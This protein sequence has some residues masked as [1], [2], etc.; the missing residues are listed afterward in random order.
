ML[1]YKNVWDG[2]HGPMPSIRNDYKYANWL[3]REWG[4]GGGDEGVGV[5]GSV[6]GLVDRK[7]DFSD[8]ETSI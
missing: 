5:Q 7:G 6:E 8:S 1:Q 4:D 3:L 2:G